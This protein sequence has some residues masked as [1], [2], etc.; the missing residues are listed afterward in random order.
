[1]SR[2]R[3]PKIDQEDWISRLGLKKIFFSWYVSL[4]MPIVCP[5]SRQQSLRTDP[6][7]SWLTAKAGRSPM[8]I[9]HSLH[10]VKIYNSCKQSTRN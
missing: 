10:T 1:M 5:K 6:G 7:N 4:G 9:L 8:G 3:K 2:S